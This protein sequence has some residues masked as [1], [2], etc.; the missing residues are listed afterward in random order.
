MRKEGKVLRKVRLA[1]NDQDKAMTRMMAVK[2]ATTSM[3]AVKISACSEFL[4]FGATIHI[5]SLGFRR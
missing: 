1:T 4:R 5:R 3:M 2:R